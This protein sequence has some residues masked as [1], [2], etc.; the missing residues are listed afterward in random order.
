MHFSFN[1]YFSL[2]LKKYLYRKRVNYVEV[3]PPSKHR[4]PLPS[5]ARCLD[6]K[7]DDYLFISISILIFESFLF[8][9]YSL[10]SL[11]NSLSRSSFVISPLPF[12]TT[13]LIG[14][15][16]AQLSTILPILVAIFGPTSIRSCAVSYEETVNYWK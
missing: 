1:E 4:A 3:T 16:Y 12:S 5:G 11:S 9:P 13:L 2:G 14:G 6:I 15:K 8:I 7:N 10:K